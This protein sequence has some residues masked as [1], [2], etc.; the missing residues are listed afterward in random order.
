MTSKITSGS[1]QQIG[2]PS[3]SE[4]LK[5]PSSQSAGDLETRATLTT[6]KRRTFVSHKQRSVQ[7]SLQS[8]SEEAR[9]PSGLSC[10]SIFALCLRVKSGT[11]VIMCSKQM[12]SSFIPHS[13]MR[14][15]LPWSCVQLALIY[16]QAHYAHTRCAASQSTRPHFHCLSL[17]LSCL[18]LTL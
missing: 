7:R 17:F 11:E 12:P 5:L 8:S 1:P 16:T 9:V 10:F 4:R 13:W 6:T 18:C 3:M 14:S 2:L 15:F